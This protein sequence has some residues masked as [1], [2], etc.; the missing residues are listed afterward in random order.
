MWTTELQ[1]CTEGETPVGIQACIP[2]LAYL[3]ETYEMMHG[4]NPRDQFAT[5]ID[6]IK[7]K[8]AA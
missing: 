2:S 3:L 6:K 5:I 8:L 1:T 4:L 7:A